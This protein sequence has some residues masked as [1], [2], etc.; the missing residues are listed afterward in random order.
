MRRRDSPRL[1][2]RDLPVAYHF[3]CTLCRFIIIHHDISAFYDTIPGLIAS[4]AITK[5]REHIVKGL[6]NGE[7]MLDVLTGG[8]FGKSVISFE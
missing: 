8:N 2:F 6:D 1:T 4:G 3:V 7:A 5:P